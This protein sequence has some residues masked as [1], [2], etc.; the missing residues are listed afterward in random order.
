MKRLMGIAVVGLATI[1][2]SIIVNVY[3]AAYTPFV[4]ILTFLIAGIAALLLFVFSDRISD[5]WAQ[6]STQRRI[7]KIEIINHEIAKITELKNDTS[8]LI[9]HVS[10]QLA[11]LIVTSF[12][13]LTF[14]FWGTFSWQSNTYSILMEQT[15]FRENWLG[16]WLLISAVSYAFVVLYFALLLQLSD[17]WKVLHYEKFMQKLK[18]RIEKLQPSN[19]AQQTPPNI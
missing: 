12:A 3:T 9:A 2:L 1:A 18:E 4:S 7:Q 6:Q 17:V 13:F 14:I 8:K 5:W 11:S 10:L 16:E 15:W 19:S